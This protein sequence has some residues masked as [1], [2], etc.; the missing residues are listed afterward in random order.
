MKLEQIKINKIKFLKKLFQNVKIVIWCVLELLTISVVKNV[1]KEKKHME[2]DVFK[3]ILMIKI[4]KIKWKT[5]SIIKLIEICNILK[6]KRKKKIFLVKKKLGVI[7]VLIFGKKKE[8]F[9]KMQ[10]K[11]LVKIKSLIF[12]KNAK[13]VILCVL[14][15]EKDSAV[16]LV[17]KVG[18][19]VLYASKFIL[20]IK[21]GKNK[22]KKSQKKEKK[23]WKW[24]W[25]N[26]NHQNV[27]TVT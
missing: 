27:K 25:N 13:T 6:K 10:W 8:N 11:K 3:L 23:E 18:I 16:M 14:E 24:K 26:Q 20:M 22:L 9:V 15:L 21:I 5:N 12:L 1:Q 4:G 7:L 19:M 2:K 17:Q